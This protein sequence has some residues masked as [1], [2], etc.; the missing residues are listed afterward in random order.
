MNGN[1][2]LD[3]GEE[4]G[5]DNEMIYEHQKNSR[6]LPILQTSKKRRNRQTDHGEPYL[7]NS[8]SRYPSRKCYSNT[9]NKQIK[10]LKLQPSNKVN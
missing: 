7:R 10:Y 4:P 5:K 8:N 3:P 2:D 6:R 9:N 1:F